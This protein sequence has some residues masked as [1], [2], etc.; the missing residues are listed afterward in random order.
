MLL[1]LSGVA[2]AKAQPAQGGSEANS[3]Y[4]TLATK[5][6]NDL[7]GHFWTGSITGGHI[8]S[9]YLGK[10]RGVL[11]SRATFL[12]VLENQWEA[13]HDPSLKLR[14]GAE[15]K[16][17]QS[18][19]THA[20]LISCGK[21]SQ[22]WGSDDVAW[23]TWMY[24]KIYG[25][26]KD[27]EALK[28]A[29][30]LAYVS[31]TRWY[32]FDYGGGLWY[33]D[34]KNGKGLYMAAN[35][36]GYLRIYEIT[37]ERGYL[38]KAMLCYDWMEDK[39]LRPDGLYW[40]GYTKDGPQG[41]NNPYG[42]GEAGSNVYFGGAMAMG[43]LHAKLYRLTRNEMYRKRAVRTAYALRTFLTDSNGV[44]IDD[45]DA[46]TNGTF[47]GDWAREVLSLP[48]IDPLD[49]KTLRDS[50]TAIYTKDRTP[51]GLYGACW[52]GPITAPNP[53]T[54]TQAVSTPD[55]ITTSSQAVSII[56]GAANAP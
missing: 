13:T 42:Y 26:T 43:V 21:G 35:A 4:K 31:F 45:R 49:I 50:A 46:W 53:W 52:D 14:I 20:E 28:C 55:Q 38:N 2:Y 1:I 39:M 30:E 51:D 37:H 19:F 22:N 27:T 16:Y 9:P 40:M 47:C 8:V 33:N 10:E 5:A 23:T 18:V 17:I 12:C 48:G 54:L 24:L 11:W 36:L 15:W 34:D 41:F 3:K 56:V 7:L 44:F 6:V 25:V 32:S 29:K